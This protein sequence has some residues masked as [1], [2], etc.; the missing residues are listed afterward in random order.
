[1]GGTFFILKYHFCVCYILG[2]IGLGLS[3]D[4]TRMRA[5]EGVRQRI[6]CYVSCLKTLMMYT[7]FPGVGSEYNILKPH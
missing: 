1:M 7:P 4:G 6:L 3:P 5:L 2:I